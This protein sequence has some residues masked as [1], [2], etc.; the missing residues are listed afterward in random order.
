MKQELQEHFVFKLGPLD[1]SDGV[2]FV[3]YVFPAPSDDYAVD[4]ILETYDAENLVFEPKLKDIA[5][6]IGARVEEHSPNTAHELALMAYEHLHGSPVRKIKYDSLLYH[7][8]QSVLNF[9]RSEPWNKS[10]SSQPLQIEISGNYEI[11]S[12]CF[13]HPH[14]EDREELFSIL[15]EVVDNVDEFTTEFS[16]IKN[17]S[18]MTVLAKSE[19]EFAV[20]AMRRAHGLNF[21]PLPYILDNGVEILVTDLQISILTTALTALV[22]L[23][24][25]ES[26]PS[27]KI[28]EI[29]L[30]DINILSQI[31]LP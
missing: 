29:N 17:R 25:E 16:S 18:R 14:S 10:W 19:P 7:F 15:F 27:S 26:S 13:I 31:Y 23:A 6:E 22:S 20:G 12:W 8:A 2:F 24:T 9:Y 4:R 5:N 11:T 28:A 30:N 3:Y 1:K 21:L